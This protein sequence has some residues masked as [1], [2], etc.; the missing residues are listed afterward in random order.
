MFLEERIFLNFKDAT[1][2]FLRMGFHR[3]L[4]NRLRCND[5]EVVITS[6]DTGRVK[7]SVE[8]IECKQVQN[9]LQNHVRADN[10]DVEYTP[11]V[12]DS[13]EKPMSVHTDT[14]QK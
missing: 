13:C 10:A 12:V 7:S 8:H 2:T 3:V 4:D 9:K 14:Q 1:E 11:K 5:L 6:M